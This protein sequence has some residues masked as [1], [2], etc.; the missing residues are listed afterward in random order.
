MPRKKM[1]QKHVFNFK[2]SLDPKFISEERRVLK[3]CSNTKSS[4]IVSR[5]FETYCNIPFFDLLYETE[6]YLTISH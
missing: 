6:T 1:P 3:G 4:T 5:K 2:L